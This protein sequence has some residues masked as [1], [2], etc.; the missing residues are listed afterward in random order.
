MVTGMG[1]RARWA[2]RPVGSTRD[3]ACFELADRPRAAVRETADAEPVTMVTAPI[4]LHYRHSASAEESRFLRALAEGRLVGQRCP[5]CGKVY[6]PP[7]SACPIDGV[8]T[9]G[10]IELPDRGTVTTF[11]IVNVP[12]A[13]QRIKPPYVA[14]YVLL[15]GADTTFQHL[16]LG[17]DAASVRMGMRVEAVWKPREDWDLTLANIDHFRPTGEPDAPFESYAEHL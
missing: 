7:R 17:C 14:A 4:H 5:E 9:E 1:V 12:F 15:D 3:I 8:P 10:D 11:C 13:G 2:E 6:V 16:V